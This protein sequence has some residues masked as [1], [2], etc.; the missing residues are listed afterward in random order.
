M[1][2]RRHTDGALQSEALYSDCQT[3]RYALTRVWQAE[4]P[5][6][7]WIM[8]NPSTATEI[9]NDP[10][11]HRCQLRAD[12]MGYGAIRIVNLFAFRATSPADLKRAADPT[13]PDNAQV[14]NTA[15]R[16]AD[17]ILPAWGVH[18]A[19]QNAG[20]AL[21]TNLR[22]RRKPVLHLGLTKDGHP[23]HPLYVAYKTTPTPLP[24]L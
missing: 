7:L 20:P 2:R 14:L 9:A 18:G 1:I 12:V 11:I 10:T 13:G 22:R 8:L 21:M 23:R 5:R 17:D 19:F 6:L 16:W 4:R 3:Y 24:K 15:L